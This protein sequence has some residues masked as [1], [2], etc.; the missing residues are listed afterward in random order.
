MM[1][2]CTHDQP[3]A[4]ED[5]L[6]RGAPVNHIDPVTT[7][8]PLMMAA[9]RGSAELVSLCLSFGAKNDPHPTFGQTALHAA[10]GAGPAGLPAAQALL[11]AAA[12]ADPFAAAAICNLT[13]SRGQTPLHCAAAGGCALT[14]ELLLDRGAE[15]ARRDERGRTALHTACAHGHQPCL[16]LLLDL[17][18]D[19]LIDA[20]DGD[21]S[22]ALLLAAEAGHALCVQL[23]L[24]SAADALI[25]DGKGRSAGEL[26]RNQGHANICRMLSEYAQEFMHSNVYDG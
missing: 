12:A 26:A 18:G 3:A 20:R 21:G 17:G 1:Y 11:S 16:A 2:A 14:M 7:D 9:R 22:T 19:A 13:D 10:V 23:L 5:A 4:L 6:L 15:A 25:R 24:E 8:T